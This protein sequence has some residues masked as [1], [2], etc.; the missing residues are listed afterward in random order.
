M[1]NCALKSQSG[2]SDW[3][4]NLLLL[5]TIQKDMTVQPFS[6]PGSHWFSFIPIS[7]ILKF[8]LNVDIMPAYVVDAL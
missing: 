8:P 6:V 2:D 7:I 3:F 5:P 4:A 1:V